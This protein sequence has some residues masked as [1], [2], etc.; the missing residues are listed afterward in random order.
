MKIQ[1]VLRYKREYDP[2]KKKKSK[3]TTVQANGATR[4]YEVPLDI[5]SIYLYT[6]IDPYEYMKIPL[7]S[8]EKGI[9]LQI[10]EQRPIY[11]ELAAALN[12]TDPQM[13][14]KLNQYILQYLTGSFKYASQGAN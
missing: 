4:I 2:D 14:S 9:E 5:S 10:N 6:P 11:H 13:F 3:S 7:V 1:S 8:G 12:P